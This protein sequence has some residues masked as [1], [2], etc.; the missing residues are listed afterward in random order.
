MNLLNENLLQIA[1]GVI[2][3]EKFLYYR[4]TGTAENEIGLN[5][6]QFAAPVELE[7]SIQGVELNIYPELGL[8]F[9]KNYRLV[10]ASANMKGIEEQDVPD[11]LEFYGLT[12]SVVK[13]VPWINYNGWNGVLVV[14]DKRER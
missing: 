13:T 9:Q 3:P 8:D 1:L 12:W 6:P 11:R 10:Y 4:F 7:G 14:E 2:P 5:V